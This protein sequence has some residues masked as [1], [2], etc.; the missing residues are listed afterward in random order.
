MS[1]YKGMQ[2]QGLREEGRTNG[3]SIC[4]I[5]I[6]KKWENCLRIKL[7]HTKKANNHQLLLKHLIL[8]NSSLTLN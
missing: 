6:L 5:P 2:I 8:I 4:F 7:P 3:L 1:S